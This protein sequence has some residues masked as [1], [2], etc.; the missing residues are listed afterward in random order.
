MRRLRGNEVVYISWIRRGKYVD[1]RSYMQGGVGRMDGGIEGLVTC[2]ELEGY[3]TLFV[4]H[5]VD[6]QDD[7]VAVIETTRRSMDYG[8]GMG[9][10]QVAALVH[11]LVG[12]VGRRI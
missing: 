6:C 3:S 11:D 7:M 5:V 2:S 10:P 12:T 1:V 9:G 4:V 8:N